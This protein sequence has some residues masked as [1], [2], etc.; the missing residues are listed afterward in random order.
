MTLL[1]QRMA[2]IAQYGGVTVPVH[3]SRKLLLS[4][5]VIIMFGGIALS[6]LAAVVSNFMRGYA[7]YGLLSLAVAVPV[8]L[9]MIWATI[10]ML[11]RARRVKSIEFTPQGMRELQRDGSAVEVISWHYVANAW[12]ERTPVDYTERLTPILTLRDGRSIRLTRDLAGGPVE[13]VRLIN[14]I[15]ATHWPNQP[16]GMQRPPGML[17]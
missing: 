16:P 4:T 8:W 14:A 7:D 15:L 11:R 13:T 1:D 2:S 9:G 10:W 17:S 12:V 3:S 6:L 5:F